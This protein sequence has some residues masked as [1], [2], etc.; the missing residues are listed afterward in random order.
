MTLHAE[1]PPATLS[2]AAGSPSG[3]A[4]LPL[5]SGAANDAAL[6]ALVGALATEQRLI[7]ELIAVMQRQRAAVGTDDLQGVDD[8][9]FATHR[10]LLTLGEARKRR[11]TL[12]GLAGCAE[13]TGVKQLEQAL[14]ARMT[15]ALRDAR[16]SL[17]EAARQL[18]SELDINRRVLREA[19]AG[20]ESFVR[21]IRGDATE[22]ASYTADGG[23]TYPGAVS[24]AFSRTA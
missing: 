9:V 7:E 12:N 14:G 22:P 10:L 18:T 16:A 2:P 4:P 1:T 24:T 3:T 11:R 19:I 13:E 5:A 23:A 20:N 21:A 15:D 6:A 17:Q 8:S